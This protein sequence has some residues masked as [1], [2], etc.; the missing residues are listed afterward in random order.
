MKIDK[1]KRIRKKKRRGKVEKE[2]GGIG[3]GVG[4]VN[5]FYMVAYQSLYPMVSSMKLPGV[6]VCQLWRSV[7]PVL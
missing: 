4:V 5:I 3:R 7:S 1:T 6:S 2:F